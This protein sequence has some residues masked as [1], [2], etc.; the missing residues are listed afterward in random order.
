MVKDLNFKY[1]E[2]LSED[3]EPGSFY[4]FPGL[5]SSYLHVFSGTLGKSLLYLITSLSASTN[6][7]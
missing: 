5:Q 7:K 4:Y 2:K 1:D 6:W 3:F